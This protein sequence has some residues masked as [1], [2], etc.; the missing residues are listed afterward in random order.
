MTIQS[1]YT[2]LANL[3]DM[4]QAIED[5]PS[6]EKLY[7]GKLQELVYNINQSEHLGNLTVWLR[8]WANGKDSIHT[9]FNHVSMHCTIERLFDDEVGF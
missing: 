5:D 8:N 9:D 3:L 7:S 4:E 6:V 1:V 2:F